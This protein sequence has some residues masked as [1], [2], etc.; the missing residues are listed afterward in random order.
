MTLDLLAIVLLPIDLF[1]L[2]ILDYGIGY[3]F[4]YGN[5]K[6]LIHLNGTCSRIFAKNGFRGLIAK[7]LPWTAALCFDLVKLNLFQH[8]HES[9]ICLNIFMKAQAVST[10]A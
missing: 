3:L 8:L 4:E 1:P 6:L 10:F 9:L 5:L 2:Q 7:V